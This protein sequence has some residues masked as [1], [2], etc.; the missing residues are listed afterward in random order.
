[1]ATRTEKAAQNVRVAAY[2][3]EVERSLRSLSDPTTAMAMGKYMKDH[4][5]FLGVKSPAR[6][7]AVKPIPAPSVEDVLLIAERLW[8]SPEREFQYVAVDL[9]HRWVK[10]LDGEET[11][12][13]I[14]RLA[15]Q[16]QWWDSVDGFA[17]VAA[18]VVRRNPELVS[19]VNRWSTDTDFWINRLAILNQ[20]GQGVAT[21]ETRLFSVCLQHASSSE[22]FIRKAIGWALRDY[23]WANPSSVRE[24]V[25]THR[26]RFSPLSRR[27]ALKNCGE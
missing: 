18:T 13:V 3:A 2:V 4:F 25:S 11:L 12:I 14:E 22:F 7:D 10:K 23:A 16:K 21:D 15:R 26:D 8:S 9:L 27:E 6:R 20:N 1:V 19:T 24:F 5:A 17:S